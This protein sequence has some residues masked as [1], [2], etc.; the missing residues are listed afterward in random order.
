MTSP[1]PVLNPSLGTPSREWADKTASSLDQPSQETPQ[2]TTSGQATSHSPGVTPGNELPG[3]FPN[4]DKAETS[5]GTTNL[6]ETIVGTARQYLPTGVANTVQTFLGKSS[7]PDKPERS[8]E[9]HASQGNNTTE[10]A[11]PD[12][13][14]R[15]SEH[16][17]LHKPSLP[18]QELG[19]ALPR[20]HVGG[21]GSLPGAS[22]EKGVAILPDEQEEWSEWNTFAGRNTPG[23]HTPSNGQSTHIP[24]W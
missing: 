12:E 6:A 9:S 8:L 5:T 10:A 24:L 23:Y 16:D 4:R 17:I 22:I 2:N 14:V 21:V 1:V 19:G 18:S 20:E 11:G 15:A 13:G 3:A 7:S